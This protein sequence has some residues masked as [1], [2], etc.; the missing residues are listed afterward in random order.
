[1]P[2]KEDPIADLIAEMKDGEDLSFMSG[3]R[4]HLFDLGCS[5]VSIVTSFLAAILISSKAHELAGMTMIIAFLSSIPALCTSLQKT[6]DF[7]KRAVWY[8]SKSAKIRRLYLSLKYGDI[9]AKDIALNLGSV[10]V[11][12][13]E[14]W[15]H[16]G[17]PE[18]FDSKSEKNKSVKG[19][20]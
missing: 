15:S 16:I 7:R 18:A 2:E 8:F 14:I 3:R 5:I 1:M 4:N 11:E 9:P 17:Q 6:I 12:M 20:I 13:E 10:E 19:R